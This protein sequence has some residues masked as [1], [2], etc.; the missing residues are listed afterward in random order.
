M[1]T[2]YWGPKCSEIKGK[3]TF[4]IAIL[5]NIWGNL[6]SM[7]NIDI[8]FNTFQRFR[9][10]CDLCLYI[11]ISSSFFKTKIILILKSSKS[12]TKATKSYRNDVEFCQKYKIYVQILQFRH[13]TTSSSKKVQTRAWQTTKQNM[14]IFVTFVNSVLPKLR[15][16]ALI[17]YWD[18]KKIHYFSLVS[19]AYKYPTNIWNFK[20]ILENN[21]KISK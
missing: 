3:T 20:I 17:F 15:K 7:Y 4:F 11:L 14:F 13:S 5:K 1:C 2:Y 18:W 12:K 9:T 6:W 19:P 8:V 10:F 16:K 21:F